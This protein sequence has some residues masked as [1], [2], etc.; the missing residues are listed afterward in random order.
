MITNVSLT[1]VWVSDLDES[2]A[3]YTDVLGFEL[4]EDLTLGPDFRWLTVGYPSQPELFVHLTTPGPPL[5]EDLIAAMRRA[6]ADGGLPGIGLTVD[7]CKAT[8]EELAAKGVVFLQEPQRRPYGI[9]ALIRD[10]S[11]NWIV[12]VEPHDYAPEDF[13][14]FSFDEPAPAD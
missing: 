8:C 2:L 3:F 7:D 14:G 1:S 13:E 11:G 12:L 9:E 6:Q 4:R 10:N 5:S